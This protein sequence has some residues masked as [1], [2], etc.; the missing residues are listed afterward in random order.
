MQLVPQ[1][2]LVQA[3]LQITIII[4]LRQLVQLALEEHIQEVV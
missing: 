4:V 2:L 1:L 3:V